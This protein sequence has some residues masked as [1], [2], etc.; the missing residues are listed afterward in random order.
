MG[1]Y[2]I[3]TFRNMI[4]FPTVSDNPLGHCR[5]ISNIQLAKSLKYQHNRMEGRKTGGRKLT[6]AKIW[7]HILTTGDKEKNNF[8]LIFFYS[9][10]PLRGRDIFRHN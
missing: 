8:S 1:N 3:E 6:R 5:E 10:S 9:S 4:K 7:T 2:N